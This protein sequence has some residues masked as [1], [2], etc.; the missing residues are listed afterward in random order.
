MLAQGYTSS[1]EPLLRL[2]AITFDPR[3]SVPQV[4][5]RFYLTLGDSD[6]F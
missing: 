2:S 3:V 1:P 4:L 5:E 6:H